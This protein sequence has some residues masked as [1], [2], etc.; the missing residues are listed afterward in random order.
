MN[1]R[2]VRIFYLDG[3]NDNVEVIPAK[4]DRIQRVKISDDLYDVHVPFVWPS[5]NFSEISYGSEFVQKHTMQPHSK[6]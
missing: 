4:P 3:V 6:R 1:H 5:S 2:S